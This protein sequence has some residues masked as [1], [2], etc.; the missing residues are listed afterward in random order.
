MLFPDVNVYVEA[1]IP[2]LPNHKRS[3]DWLTQALSGRE[4][5]AIWEPVM[6]SV[7][8]VSTRP[9]VFEPEVLIEDLISFLQVVRGSPNVVALQPGPKFWTLFEDLIRTHGVAGDLVTD[10][11]IAA[12]AMENDCT[13]VSSDRDFA[14]FSNLKWQIPT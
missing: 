4:A 3:R 1:L 14:R 9:K 7:V 12:L 2:V 8:R 6:C 10:A 11:M 13:V 5:V